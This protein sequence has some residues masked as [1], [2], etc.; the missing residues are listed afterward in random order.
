[1]KSRDD[2][3][4]PPFEL[5]GD[6]AFCTNFDIAAG[7]SG[8]LQ[9][10]CCTCD[11]NCTITTL[12][13]CD[14]DGGLW[15]VTADSCNDVTCPAAGPP[16]NDQCT[17]ME[18]LTAGSFFFHNVCANTEGLNPVT[19]ELGPTT[20]GNDIWFS[21]QTDSPCFLSFETCY[22]NFD[23]VIAVYHDPDNPD[24]CLCPTDE[25][26]ESF[27]L[28]AADENCS[29]GSALGGG[30]FVSGQAEGDCGNPGC[31]TIR[32]GGFNGDRGTVL[33][34]VNCAV[35]GGFGLPSPPVVDSSPAKTRFISMEIPEASF[36]CGPPGGGQLAVRVTFTSLHHVNPPYNIG[37]S[38]PFTAFEGQVRWVG[39]PRQYIES[40]STPSPFYASMLQCTPHYRD[41][42]TVG[43]LH[44]TGSA[45]VPSSIYEVQTVSSSCAGN[46]QNC[47]SVSAPVTISTS[48]WADVAEPYNPPDPTTQ[49]NISDMVAMVNKFRGGPG[50]LIKARVLIAAPNAFGEITV[51]VL[52]NDF[53]F[54]HIASCVDA[55]RGNPYPYKMGMCSGSPTPPA[56]GACTTDDDCLGANGTGP[57]KLFA[58][59]KCT[60]APNGDCSTDAQCLGANGAPPCIRF[61]GCP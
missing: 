22:S 48:R 32:I 10:P 39:P 6:Y 52:T 28:G 45:I 16:A 35:P 21:Y 59:G 55:F 56:T 49:P 3:F 34:H 17:G 29:D 18:P 61:Y 13:Q 26:L 14:A 12:A 23:T 54:S 20:I 46:E 58:M 36:P 57:C 53:N 19:T 38:T 40:S 11:G 31:Y 2:Y 30:G 7:G 41:W 27:L 9:H 37:P 47:L 43:L 60:G 25:N 5:A 51:P 15:D 33:L 50:G 44:V 42:S 24:V 4:G 8:V 1:M